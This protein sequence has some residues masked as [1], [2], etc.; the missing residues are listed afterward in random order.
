V[1]PAART[2]RDRARVADRIHPP[3]RPGRRAPGVQHAMDL[4][5]R[6][7]APAPLPIVIPRGGVARRAAARLRRR[8]A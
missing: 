4:P 2:R 8:P 7:H 6:N 3:V 1:S 5:D